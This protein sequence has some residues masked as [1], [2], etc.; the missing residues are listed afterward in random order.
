VS[1]EPPCQT[2]IR[3]CE[4]ASH[5][6]NFHF[7][8]TIEWGIE[9]HAHGRCCPRMHASLWSIELENEVGVAVGHQRR[10]QKAWAGVDHREDTQPG[11]HSVEVAEL[12]LQARELGQRHQ[13]GRGVSLIDGYL[14]S[15]LTEWLCYGSIWIEGKMSRDEGTIATNAHP[16]ERHPHTRWILEGLGQDESKLLEF[17]FDEHI[18]DS[19]GTSTS[20]SLYGQSDDIGHVGRMGS[21]VWNRSWHRRL[22]LTMPPLRL[23]GSA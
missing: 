3:R 8:F 21:S 2:Q 7:G 14:G 20:M 10:T 9:R 6:V 12:S 18:L 15:N 23:D 19:F 13:T 4:I 1:S 16:R 11:G 5:P 17:R 22:D